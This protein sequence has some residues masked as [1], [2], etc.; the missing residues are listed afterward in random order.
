MLE[1]AGN[2]LE[3]VDGRRG[4][5]LDQR[6]ARLADV[7]AHVE[8]DAP[9]VAVRRADVAGKVEHPVDAALLVVAPADAEPEA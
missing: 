8:E 2:G 7:G 3:R 1:R 5:T 6:E 4:K 9:P